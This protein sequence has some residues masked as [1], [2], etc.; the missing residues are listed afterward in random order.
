MT[1][2]R[3]GLG[4][5][6]VPGQRIHL[7]DG[8]TISTTTSTQMAWVRVALVTPTVGTDTASLT[9]SGLNGDMD[10]EYWMKYFVNAANASGQLSNI[11]FHPMDTSGNDITGLTS[12]EWWDIVGAAV[13]GGAV[14]P[15]GLNSMGSAG[16]VA[17]T[18]FVLSQFVPNVSTTGDRS[19]GQ[20]YFTAKTGTSRIAQ[21]LACDSS[22]VTSSAAHIE[23]GYG[24]FANTTTTVGGIKILTFPSTS[25]TSDSYVEVWAPRSVTMVLP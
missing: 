23:H 8:S 20:I 22:V 2:F 18:S 6:T 3:I 7:V 14:G 9:A 11:Y 13:G 21:A 19:Q 15:V 5:L 1:I 10:G 4:G 25:L 24:L 12:Q 16:A 17:A